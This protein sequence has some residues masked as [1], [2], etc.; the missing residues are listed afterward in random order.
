VPKRKRDEV[1]PEMRER[2]LANR[3]GRLT[4][5]Q[6]LDLIAQP[7][8][9][10]VVLS[11]AAFIVFGAR[12]V[13]LLRVWWILLPVIGLL[14]VLPVILR[15]YRYARAPIHFAR[16]YGNPQARWVFWQQQTFHTDADE[17][18]AFRHRLAPR[19]PLKLNHEYL[20]YF[21]DEPSGKVLLSVAPAD[22]EDADLWL[23]TRHFEARYE[24]RTGQG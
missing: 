3:S 20:V 8:I 18:V 4:V 22:H 9:T 10:L 21:L 6:W 11:G 17:L 19:L 13:A 14:V 5:G 12:M 2:L 15:A 16:L 23:P 7:L 24:R 1:V